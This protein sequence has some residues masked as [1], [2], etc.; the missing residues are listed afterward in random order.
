MP[1]VDEA[2]W[3]LVKDTTDSNQL[4]L[5]VER[6]PRSQRRREAEQRMATLAAADA[7]RR[8]EEE[9]RIAALQAEAEQRL[10]A[11][12]AEAAAAARKA[13][14][15]AAQKADPRELARS[16]QF[17]LTRVGCYKGTVDGEYG[18]ATRE[19]LQNFAKLAAVDIKANELSPE[20]IKAI[21]EFDKRVCPLVCPAGQIVKDDACVAAPAA[22]PK[23]PVATAPA[24]QRPAPKA[25][26]KCFAFQGRQFCE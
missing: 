7:A 17:E 3:A 1:A 10:A 8:A 6:F 26:G 14:L 18:R 20:I 24:P 21:R 12:R 9:K 23:K 5:F 25:G 4:K 19:A 13:G 22:A 2:A 15:D 16:L 11:L